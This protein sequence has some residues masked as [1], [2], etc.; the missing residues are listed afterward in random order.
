MRAQPLRGFDVEVVA[1]HRF[2]VESAG[3]R[4]QRVLHNVEHGFARGRIGGG[5]I[6]L[7]P[8]PLGQ[9]GGHLGNR[10]AGERVADQDNV[11][12][13]TGF[14]IGDDV[15]DE[16]GAGDLAQ[17]F[18]VAAP[19]AAAEVDGQS[20]AST[21][22]SASRNGTRRAQHQAPWA[23]PCTSTKLVTIT[24]RSVPEGGRVSPAS[25]RVPARD[26]FP[27]SRIARR[28]PRTPLRGT[29]LGRPSAP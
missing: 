7:P 28:W 12:K 1:E 29:A 18:D 19:A 16:I 14:D 22:G 11:A 15:G 3:N 6:D 23:P 8:H 4:R 24:P 2:E 10:D 13:V 25:V 17:R 27:R 9:P 20:T 26:S 21:R 5:E